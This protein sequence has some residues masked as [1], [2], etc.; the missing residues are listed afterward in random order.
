MTRSE[1][2]TE[3]ARRLEESTSSPVYWTTGDLNDA[4]DAGYEEMADASEWYEAVVVID[5]LRSRLWYDLRRYAGEGFLAPGRAF[6]ETTNRWL[7]PRT[8]DDLDHRDRRWE[9]RVEAAH[10]L[11]LRS[12]WW[13]G[14]WPAKDAEVGTIKQSFTALPAALTEDTMTPGFPEAF[15]YGLVEYALAELW[16]QDG[17]T[18]RALRAWDAYRGYETGLVSWVG[19]RASTPA[20]LGH[21][22]EGATH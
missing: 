14:Y 5:V 12:L 2:R 22:P 1:I 20:V 11:L 7:H 10:T 13:V 8:A 4:I 6:N 16:A 9:T 19:N 18:D 3:I 17:E 15:H 21:A